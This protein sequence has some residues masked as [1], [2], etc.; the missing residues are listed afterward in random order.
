MKW[1]KLK[2][3]IVEE[4]T[5]N[6]NAESSKDFKRIASES[7]TNVQG[8]LRQYDIRA[9]GALRERFRHLFPVYLRTCMLWVYTDSKGRW[10]IS[11]RDRS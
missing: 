8:Y 1:E 9:V 10:T 11:D 7:G 5:T 2:E 6:P 4:V 3:L